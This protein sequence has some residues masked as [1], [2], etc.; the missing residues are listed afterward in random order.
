LYN[1]FAFTRAALDR[2]GLFDENIY[3]AYYE[4]NDFQLRQNR[5]QPPMRVRVLPDVVMMH[6][7]P[8]ESNYSSGVHTADDPND[9]HREGRMRSYWQHRVAINRAYLMRKWGCV[10]EK[11]ST[12]AYKTP[13]N[14]S[15][16]VWCAN[17]C[18]SA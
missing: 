2:F 18:C 4:D 14:K 9:L 10:N 5:T 11:W 16:P 15:L 3:P 12:C 6:G 17:S 7:Q 8:T 13:F 1:T